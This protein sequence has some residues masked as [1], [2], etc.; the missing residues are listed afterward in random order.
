MMQYAKFPMK[1]VNITQTPDNAFSHKGSVSAWDNAGKDSGIDDVFAPFD[2]KVVWI[3][4][5]SAKTGVLIQNT[6]FVQ[7]ADGLVREPNNIKLLTWH[8]NN[9]NDLK[10]GQL[11][12]QGQVYYQEGTAGHA[13]GNHAHFNVGIGKHDGK[14]PLVKNEFGVWEI[15]GE[16]DPTKIFFID[17][18]NEVKEMK[19]MKW[20]KH[21]EKKEEQVAVKPIAEVKKVVVNGVV[22]IIGTSYATGQ[23]I[24][25]WVKVKTYRVSKIDGDKAL[26]NVI[27]SWVKLKDL[28]AL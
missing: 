22:K 9:I 19:G 26:L 11:I 16:I 13:T 14:Y 17:D 10:V 18:L 8:D 15:K 1:V 25:D 20:I 5:G 27:N 23:K 2:C 12:K 28:V 3:D 24:P 7:C 21:V 4:T 6:D